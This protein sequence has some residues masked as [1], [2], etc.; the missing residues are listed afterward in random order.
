MTSIELLKIGFMV[1]CGWW[2]SKLI[3]VV[4]VTQYTGKNIELSTDE[5]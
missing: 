3:F 2:I 4:M 5:N 1:G